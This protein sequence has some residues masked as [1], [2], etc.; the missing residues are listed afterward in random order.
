MFFKHIDLVDLQN[1]TSSAGFDAN[2]CREISIGEKMESTKK[3]MVICWLKK[4]RQELML[5]SAVQFPWIKF[6]E[7]KNISEVNFHGRKLLS[8]QS[9]WH[10]FWKKKQACESLLSIVYR[11]ENGVNKENKLPTCFLE[12][13]NRQS[14]MWTF[15]LKCWW[16]KNAAQTSTAHGLKYVADNPDKIWMSKI[17]IY[18][19]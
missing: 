19:I 11:W 8:T 7:S 15:A 3:D 18:K 12:K 10:V 13:T 1:K 2:L 4:N 17:H 14:L 9:R 16:M 6:M 5:T